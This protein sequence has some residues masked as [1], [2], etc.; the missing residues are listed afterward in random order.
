MPSA[1]ITA[2]Y[3]PHL[4]V[5]NNLIIFRLLTIRKRPRRN[6]GLLCVLK[7]SVK[8]V[9]LFVSK[10]I[11]TSDDPCP[12]REFDAILLPRFLLLSSSP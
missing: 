1:A 5:A 10:E 7:C 9:I 8:L 4:D 11:C 3:F 2:W 6:D 12:C